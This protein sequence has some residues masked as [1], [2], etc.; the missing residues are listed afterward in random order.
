MSP[1]SVA[2]FAITVVTALFGVSGLFER[3]SL[4]SYLF[5]FSLLICL[6]SLFSGERSSLSR[7]SLLAKD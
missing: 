3:S 7:P 5:G 4:P 1:S 2:L 6:L